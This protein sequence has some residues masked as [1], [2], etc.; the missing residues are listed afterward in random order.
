MVEYNILCHCRDL[1]QVYKTN[2]T[3][4]LLIT[5]KTIF[6]T[7]FTNT[8][9]ENFELILLNYL[10]EFQQRVEHDQKAFL[11]QWM[12]IMFSYLIHE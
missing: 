2:V 3:G 4:Y 11:F 8:N 12:D 7:C 5:R 6:D 9:N 1:N 10:E